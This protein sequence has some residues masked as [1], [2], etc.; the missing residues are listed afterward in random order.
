[1]KAQAPP[2]VNA[3]MSAINAKYK[4]K[5]DLL[6]LSQD[7][8]ANDVAN[9][10]KGAMGLTSY[11]S[12]AL[13]PSETLRVRRAAGD[14]S[15]EIQLSDGA[16]GAA[17]KSAE[18]QY[19]NNL[20]NKK[21]PVVTVSAL[22]KEY[23]T[24][25]PTTPLSLTSAGAAELV[26]VKTSTITITLKADKVDVA[27]ANLLAKA[28][29]EI[30][31]SASATG[32]VLGLDVAGIGAVIGVDQITLPNFLQL[33]PAPANLKCWEA[34]DLRGLTDAQCKSID[35]NSDEQ[36]DNAEYT[37]AAKPLLKPSEASAVELE[38]A[39][40]L[41]AAVNKV[42]S[43]AE[44]QTKIDT[45]S[46]QIADVG[47][48]AKEQCDKLAKERG[49]PVPFQ[50][51]C[52][53]LIQKN[54]PTPKPTARPTPVDTSKLGNLG[55]NGDA[56]PPEK[57]SS[58]T[59]II[60]ICVIVCVVIIAGGAVYI[61]IKRRNMNLKADQQM[62]TYANPTYAAGGAGMPGAPAGGHLGVA[63]GAGAPGAAAPKLV[64]Q[65]SLC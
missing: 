57:S 44:K 65:E 54:K 2:Q 10:L 30:T 40:A 58:N 43:A 6:K 47:K 59:A 39:S 3:A 56:P 55:N 27:S 45:I 15:L 13:V 33:F 7:Q 50:G 5:P 60:V 17:A 23:K 9:G 20:K 28:S 12:A 26:Q 34:T 35:A 22:G 37:I 21:L 24:Y 31:D 49:L 18:Q 32:K 16:D 63:E 48:L 14:Y 29:T 41:I 4:D 36:I 64:R 19:N 53:D 62:S 11:K 38:L 25:G 1:V 46:Q 52:D 42:L 61:Y 8:M 51:N